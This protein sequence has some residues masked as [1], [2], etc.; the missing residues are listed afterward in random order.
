MQM[1]H[2]QKYKVASIMSESPVVHASIALTGVWIFLTFA[3]SLSRKFHLFII[4]L[5]QYLYRE[6]TDWN[7]F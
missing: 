6:A 4:Y 2:F 3:L 5:Q 7:M 1:K